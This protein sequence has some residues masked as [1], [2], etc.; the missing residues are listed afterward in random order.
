MIL[1][2]FFT[3]MILI[4][5]LHT[6]ASL[7]APLARIFILFDSYSTDGHFFPDPQYMHVQHINC[8]DSF[9]TYCYDFE[10]EKDSRFSRYQAFYLQLSRLYVLEAMH[11]FHSLFTQ[12]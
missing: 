11:N 12:T 1:I 6:S 4:L 5:Q 3:E 8:C 10:F 7:Y 9:A 2:L